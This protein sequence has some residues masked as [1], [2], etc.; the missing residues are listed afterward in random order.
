MSSSIADSGYFEPESVNTTEI[1][2]LS[3]DEFAPYQTEIKFQKADT[4]FNF[5]PIVLSTFAAVIGVSFAYF[6]LRK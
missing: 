4:H 2:T 6:R 1:D 5:Y 3:D